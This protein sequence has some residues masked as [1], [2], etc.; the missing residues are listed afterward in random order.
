MFTL[1]SPM[2]GTTDENWQVQ[3]MTDHGWRWFSDFATQKE[4]HEM[5]RV[6]V[7]YYPSKKFRVVK[8]R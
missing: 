8:T 4:A 3:E 5:R 2:D 7:S 6:Y 1:E